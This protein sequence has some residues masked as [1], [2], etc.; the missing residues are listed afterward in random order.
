[1]KE[2]GR[3]LGVDFGTVRVG[4][5][6]SDPDRIIASPLTTYTRK[7]DS[8]D[9]VFFKKQLKEHDFVGIVLGMPVH[10]NGTHGEKAIQAEKYGQW[11]HEIL[12]IPVIH[13]DERFTTVEAQN[14]LL[15]AN[16]T[17]KKRKEK[18]DR[19][20]AQILL[21]SYLDAGCPNDMPILGLDDQT[22]S[23]S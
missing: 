2:R 10:L 18:I 13:W 8:D 17:R 21:Q 14:W 1:M 5:A 19:I 12:Q 16:V 6:I 23:M 20:A 7:F 9:A 11:L 22:E 4:L 3:L 15:S